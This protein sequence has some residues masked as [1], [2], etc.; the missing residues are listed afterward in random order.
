MQ[1]MLRLNFSRFLHIQ[2][3]SCLHEAIIPRNTKVLAEMTSMPYW[4]D[5]KALCKVTNFQRCYDV[6]TK[7][8]ERFYNVAF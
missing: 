5:F 2:V 1:E 4:Q 8:P 3:S 6:G 7:F